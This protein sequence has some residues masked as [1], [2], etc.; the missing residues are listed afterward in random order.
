MDNIGESYNLKFFIYRKN[1]RNK[2]SRILAYLDNIR[3]SI[4]GKR[5]YIKDNA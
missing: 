3:N 1:S 5:R 4:A 2:P